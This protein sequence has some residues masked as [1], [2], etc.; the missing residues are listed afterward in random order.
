M[1]I[2][3][4]QCPECTTLQ[5]AFHKNSKDNEILC[6]ICDTPCKKILSA[7]KGYVKNTTTPTKC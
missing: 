6:V 2:F 7:T 1:P 4:Y 3:E 5:E